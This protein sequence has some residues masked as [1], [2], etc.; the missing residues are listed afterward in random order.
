MTNKYLEKI[1]KAMKGPASHA[2]SVHNFIDDKEAVDAKQRRGRRLSAADELK[3]K[4]FKGRVGAAVGGAAVLG[5]AA[6]A[7]KKKKKD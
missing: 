7:L 3:G 5:A 6:M 4:K 1:A 2:S